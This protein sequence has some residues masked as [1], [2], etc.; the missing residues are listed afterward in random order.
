MVM[1]MMIMLCTG[2]NG[3][4]VDD[5]GDD[6]DDVDDDDDANYDVDDDMVS[7]GVEPPASSRGRHP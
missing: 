4:V 6:D 2:D 1:G 7:A 5:D 3:D